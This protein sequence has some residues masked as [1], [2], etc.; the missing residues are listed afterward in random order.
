MIDIQQKLT[1]YLTKSN[2]MKRIIFALIISLSTTC[3]F[4]QDLQFGVRGGL[5]A[6]SFDAYAVDNRIN[7]NVF[8]NYNNYYVKNANKSSVGIYVGGTV[9]FSLAKD[10]RLQ[11]EINLIAVPGDYGYVAVGI[12]VMFKYSFFDK[13]YALAGPGLNFAVNADRDNFS[14]TFSLGASYDVMKD[15]YVEARADIGLCG[16]LS[17]NVNAGVGYRF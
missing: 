9:D 15:F 10:F 16:Y 11:P 17:N 1:L 12:P 7:K 3:I 14:P 8:N 2:I 6:S 5:M 4:A 13:F